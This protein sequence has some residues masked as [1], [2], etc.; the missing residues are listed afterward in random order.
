[1]AMFCIYRLKNTDLSFK[2]QRK[3]LRIGLSQE[4]IDNTDLV[5]FLSIC[6]HPRP[7][8]SQQQ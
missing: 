8:K 5:F 7:K 3:M 1:M 2:I 4:S 6:T